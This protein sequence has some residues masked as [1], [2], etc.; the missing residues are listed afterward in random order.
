ML[1][2]IV[3]LTIDRLTL[4]GCRRVV[5]F[6][7]RVL[8]IHLLWASYDDRFLSYGVHNLTAIINNYSLLAFAHAQYH[9]IYL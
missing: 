1:G 7:S 3:T 9:E 8:S 6:P 5:D 4:N 2:Y